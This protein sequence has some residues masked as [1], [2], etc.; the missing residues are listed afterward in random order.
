VATCDDRPLAGQEATGGRRRGGLPEIRG[1]IDLGNWTIAGSGGI[2]TRQSGAFGNMKQFILKLF[3]WWNSQTFGTQLWTWRFGE[4]VGSDEQGNRYYRNRGRAIDPAL[5]FERR[6]VVYNG[7]AEGS[8][9]PPAWHSWLHHVVDLPPT[10]LKEESRKWEQPHQPN[11][12][13]TP[14]AY[15]PSG[16]MAGSGRPRVTGD[17]QPWTPG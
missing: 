1:K 14:R 16:S 10:E 4:L 17:Y 5:G 13:G 2:T 9:V 3:T 6:W 11:P 7:Y 15:H 12:T 8:R